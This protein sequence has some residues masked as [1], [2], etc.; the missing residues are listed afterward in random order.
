MNIAAPP[1]INLLSEILVFPS[2]LFYSIWLLIPLGMIRFLAAVYRLFLYVRTQHGGFPKFT[3]SFINIKRNGL[4][5]LFLHYLPVNG[6]ILK[7]DVI[8]G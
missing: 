7:A 6:I 5:L 8:C 2:V 1:S 4:L 3:F